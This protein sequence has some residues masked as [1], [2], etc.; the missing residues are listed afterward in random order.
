L[1]KENMH[2]QPR[3]V[4]KQLWTNTD[5]TLVGVSKPRQMQTTKCHTSVK[6]PASIEVSWPPAAVSLLPGTE[7]STYER[8]AYKQC[9]R[10]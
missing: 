3:L 4:H 7:D 10:Q 9:G 5:G 2:T 1:P 6:G 8:S